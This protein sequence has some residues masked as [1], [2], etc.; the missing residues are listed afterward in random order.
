LSCGHTYNV[1]N[2]STIAA[3][4]TSCIASAHRLFQPNNCLFVLRFLL[5]V[6][7]ASDH[8]LKSE[9]CLSG[10]GVIKEMHYSPND[11]RMTI[12]YADDDADDCELVV[13]ALEKIDPR[14]NCVMVNDGLQALRTLNEEKKLPDYII[15]DVNMPVMDGKNCLIELKKDDRLKE[16]PV[17]IYSTSQNKEEINELYQMGAS[18][19]LRKPNSFEDLCISLKA[20]IGKLQSQAA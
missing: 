5:P 7:H 18:E 12:L 3:R 2:K 11:T 1:L 4:A 10:R 13:E 6:G 16:I 19:Y 20:V 9:R 8:G 17:V 14:I 15:L